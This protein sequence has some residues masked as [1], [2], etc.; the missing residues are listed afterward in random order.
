[1]PSGES[2][3]GLHTPSM[4]ALCQMDP[5]APSTTTSSL[6]RVGEAART[7]GEMSVPFNGCQ[8]LQTPEV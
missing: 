1:M 3:V 2:H 6:F 5:D 7:G 4:N 8:P